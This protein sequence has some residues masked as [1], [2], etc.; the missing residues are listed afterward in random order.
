[1]KL[2][3][4]SQKKQKGRVVMPKSAL[5]AA[6]KIKRKYLNKRVRTKKLMK[7]EKRLNNIVKKLKDPNRVKKLNLWIRDNIKVNS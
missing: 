1:M 5:L 2:E 3:T 6:D 4:F 7:H